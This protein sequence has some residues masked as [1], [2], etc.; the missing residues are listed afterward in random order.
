MQRVLR[1]TL[2]HLCCAVL[3]AGFLIMPSSSMAAEFIAEI[4]E[5]YRNVHRTYQQLYQSDVKRVQNEY[6]IYQIEMAEQREKLDDFLEADVDD[7]LDLFEKDYAALEKRYGNMK[8]YQDEL[9]RYRNQINPDYASGAMWAYENQ[10]D[11]HYSSSAHWRFK[12]A[13]NPDY[14]SSP[15][16]KYKNQANPD[17]SSSIMWKYKNEFNENYSSSTMWKL[18]NESNANYTG[19][20]MWRYKRG[21]L[22]EAEAKA[23]MQEIFDDSEAELN[24]IRN[25]AMEQIEDLRRET[26]RELDNRKQDTIKEIQRRR[27][28][29]IDDINE[30]RK[31]YFGGVLTVKPLTLN[32]NRIAVWIDGELQQFDQPPVISN[33]STLVPMRAIFEALGADVTYQGQTKSV[34]AAKGDTEIKLQLGSKEATVNGGRIPL[35]VPAQTVNNYTMVPL[36]FVSEALGADVKWVSETTTVIITTE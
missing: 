22:T 20:I 27:K 11:E 4:E 34:H 6:R 16:W 32:I 31:R 10:T 30:L 15:M 36:R 33:G 8:S 23:K 19:S 25:S 29:S 14:S 9:R 28:K 7:L 17:Y 35:S 13:V 26:L 3:A 12:N 5:K 24:R 2:F 21:D 1:F 18:K